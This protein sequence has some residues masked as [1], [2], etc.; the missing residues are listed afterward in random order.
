MIM[1]E[2]KSYT[3]KAW[4]VSARRTGVPLEGGA[5]FEDGYRQFLF[6]SF[7]CEYRVRIVDV[8]EKIGYCGN[9]PHEGWVIVGMTSE[10]RAPWI[11]GEW[12]AI[13]DV[14]CHA[15]NKSRNYCLLTRKKRG[16]SVCSS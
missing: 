9:I 12:P 14:F 15:K 10:L 13:Y 8:E 16:L 5:M 1:T 11:E 3:V 7:P 2:R 6:I 4:S